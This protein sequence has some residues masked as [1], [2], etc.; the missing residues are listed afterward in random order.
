MDTKIGDEIV[1]DF[2]GVRRSRRSNGRWAIVVAVG[3]SAV[4][5]LEWFIRRTA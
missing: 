4:A 3:C 2:E 5:G 1:A